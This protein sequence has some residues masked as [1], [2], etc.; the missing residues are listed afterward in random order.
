MRAGWGDGAESGRWLV[1]GGRLSPS[2]SGW[3]RAGAPADG[4]QDAGD[5]VRGE[6]RRDG[7]DCSD[8]KIRSAAQVNGADPAHKIGHDN[9]PE[10]PRSLSGAPRICYPAGAFPPIDEAPCRASRG[11]R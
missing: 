5:G 7:L 1:P 2:G 10:V 6:D 8:A 3:R 11:S 4:V 9:A